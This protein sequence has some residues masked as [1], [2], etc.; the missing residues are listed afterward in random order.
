[1]AVM[2]TSVRVLDRDRVQ[3]AHTTNHQSP[4][5][6]PASGKGQQPAESGGD[7][8]EA[9]ADKKSPIKGGGAGAEY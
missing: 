2:P 4:G 8:G 9:N 7:A 6:G 3:N 5:K 1:M